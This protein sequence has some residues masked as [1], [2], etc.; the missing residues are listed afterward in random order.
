MY[1]PVSLPKFLCYSSE[2]QYLRYDNLEPGIFFRG[3]YFKMRSSKSWLNLIQY[4]RYP[5]RECEFGHS[6]RQDD[7]NRIGDTVTFRP[8]TEFRSAASLTASRSLQTYQHVDLEQLISKTVRQQAFI[9]SVTNVMV[10]FKV[11]LVNG[12]T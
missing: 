3:I 8:R 1:C 12:Y 7:M 4:V 5:S 2:P 10:N 11:A 9:I 6:F